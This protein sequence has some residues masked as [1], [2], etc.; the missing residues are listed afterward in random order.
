MV[1]LTD[2]VLRSDRAADE[3]TADGHMLLDLETGEYFDL[4]PVGGFIWQRL[5]GSAELDAVAAQVVARFDV[6]DDEARR[7]LLAF[8]EQ[9]LGSGLAR[10]V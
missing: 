10:V 3:A 7:D 5:D 6:A 2:R 1:R 8:V 4:G 9:L